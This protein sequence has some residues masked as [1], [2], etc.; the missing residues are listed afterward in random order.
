MATSGAEQL[1]AQLRD[2]Q[3][4][5]PVEPALA[6][7]PTLAV[8]ALLPALIVV[9]AA[10]CWLR[11]RRL[12]AALRRLKVLARQHAGDGD[13]VRLAAGLSALLRQ[14]ALRCFPGSPAARLID[15]DWLAFLDAHGGRGEFRHG[16][17]A[18]LATLPY[19]PAADATVDVG[20]L[21]ALAER[22]LRANPG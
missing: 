9:A 10:T 8:S 13:A 11:R 12:R 1:L 5:L 6:D 20:A 21:L 2:I 16:P 14:Q 19:R 7:W 22:W 18:A 15:D 3:L 17:G 4:P